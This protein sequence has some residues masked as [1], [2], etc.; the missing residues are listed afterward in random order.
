MTTAASTS[1]RRPW[2]PD[3]NAHL[4]F[5][6]V[7]LEGKTQGWVASAFGINQ[8]TVS[9]IL[10]RYE[11]WQAHAREREGGRLDPSERLRAQRWLTFE[12]NELILTSCLRIANEMEGFTD[13][14]KSTVCHPASQPNKEREVRT[15]H[16]RIDRSGVAARFLRLA[17]RINMEQLK[18]AELDPPPP[19]APLSAEELAAEDLQA[20]ADAQELLAA[21]RHREDEAPADAVGWAPPTTEPPTT[22]DGPAPSASAPPTQPQPEPTA[23][24]ATIAPSLPPSFSP[25]LPP[26]LPLNPEPQ[27]LNPSPAPVHN[28]HNLH[29]E[30]PSE[31]AAT[32]AKP[33]TCAQH[34]RAERNSL[35][36]C[37]AS[38]DPHE[39]PDDDTP[40]QPLPETCTVEFVH[41]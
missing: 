35:T 33:C 19:A 24:P 32:A 30:N 4:I 18:L 16:S 28:L 8:A 14:S 38:H 9:R 23:P 25:S 27:T 22:T 11:R 3:G 36:P 41:A 1:S 20:A 17:F 29:N 7:K 39:W 31:I 6:W 15:E 12:R 34:P 40:N 21:R 13:V 26:A 10:Q 2:S 37:I 5:Q